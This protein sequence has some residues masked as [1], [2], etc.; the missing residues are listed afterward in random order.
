MPSRASTTT[1][2]VVTPPTVA[3]RNGSSGHGLPGFAMRFQEESE[4]EPSCF[5][6]FTAVKIV[7]SLL[8]SLMVLPSVLLVVAQAGPEPNAHA[9]NAIVADSSFVEIL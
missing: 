7:F 5:A 4:D 8:V 2:T 3:S 1:R 6:T 9:V